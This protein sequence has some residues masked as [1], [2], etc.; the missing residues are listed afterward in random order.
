MNT[1]FSEVDANGL[2]LVL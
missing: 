2:N 1:H